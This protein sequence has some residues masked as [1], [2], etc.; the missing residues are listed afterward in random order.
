MNLLQFSFRDMN[1]GELEYI[2]RKSSSKIPAKHFQLIS[3][4]EGKKLYLK[5]KEGK[6]N[7][8]VVV[9]GQKG[10]EAKAKTTALLRR[11]DQN[12]GWALAPN[13][14]HN[15]GK[16]V[17]TFDEEGNPVRLSLHLCPET[18]V[19]KDIQNYIGSNTQTNPFSL[20]QEVSG[21][22]NITSRKQLGIDYHL[23]LDIRANLVVPTNRADD[24]VNKSNTMGSTISGATSSC[25]YAAAKQAPLVEHVLYDHQQFLKH[26]NL[27]IREFNDNIKHDLEFSRLGITDLYSLGT[28]LQD[29]TKL[30]ENQR[31]SALKAK[32]SQGEIDFFS[33]EHPAQ[34][35]LEQYQRIIQSNLFYV[36]DCRAEIHKHLKEGR[37]GIIEGV[38]SS[39]LS[40]GIAYTNNKHASTTH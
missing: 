31:L 25:K 9:G 40:G 20:E 37:S 24:A 28:A 5:K 16:G 17:H 23:M 4:E 22:R 19:E 39:L 32:L 8:Y 21:M 29:S 1:E 14:T 30:E 34:F 3:D 38:Q 7:V 33:H 11:M 27:Q 12:V 15:A 6:V 35:L 36:G 10:D 13:S 2:L 26:V 18:V